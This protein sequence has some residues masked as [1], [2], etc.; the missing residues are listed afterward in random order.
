[1]PDPIPNR[2]EVK[3]MSDDFFD[4]GWEEMALAGALAEEMAEEAKE[5]RKL[6]QESE[7]EESEYCCSECEPSEPCEPPDPPFE[8][9]DEDPYP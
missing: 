5:R 7:I 4:I 6:E 1:L 9:P 8:P 2:K 3:S